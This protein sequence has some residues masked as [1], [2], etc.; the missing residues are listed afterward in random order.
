[1]MKQVNPKY[2]PTILFFIST[3][4]LML[5]CLVCRF[6]GISYFANNYV[7]HSLNPI[8]QDFIN[9]ALKS[10]EIITIIS[11]LS[12][13]KWYVNV[14]IGFTFSCIYWIPMNSST[15]FILDLAVTFLIPFILNKF[16]PET[17]TYSIILF[18]FII[19]YQFLVMQARY[20]IDLE[21]K[22]NYIAGIVSVLD[23]KLFIINLYFIRRFLTMKMNEELP[24]ADEENFDGGHCLFFFGPEK[25]KSKAAIIGHI[26]GFP[27]FVII[28]GIE[29]TCKLIKNSCKKEQ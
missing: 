12:V 27:I 15:V 3:L 26:I 29:F 4:T 2:R 24:K 5:F 10:I 21:S 9:F 16:N 7:E 6:C 22:F 19:L 23:Y 25:L 28:Y 20:T 18:I 11:I 17:I 1:M 14:L 8:L 13:R